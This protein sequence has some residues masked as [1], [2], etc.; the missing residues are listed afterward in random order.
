MYRSRDDGVTKITL[1]HLAE[2]TGRKNVFLFRVVLTVYHFSAVCSSTGT[3]YRNERK[4]VTKA[5][6]NRY[7]RRRWPADCSPS[8][9]SFS[10]VSARTTA[11]S[12]YGEAKIWNCRLR[13]VSIR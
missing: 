10:N 4:N 1:V 9:R 2:E 8:T 6:P 11:V 12:T 5:P 3:W 7:G 13:Y